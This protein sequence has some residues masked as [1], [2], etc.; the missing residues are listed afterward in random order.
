MRG[1]AEEL[2]PHFQTPSF[3]NTNFK[4]IDI[5]SSVRLEEDIIIIG[6]VVAS[7]FICWECVGKECRNCS[8]PMACEK[9]RK[10]G[11][12]II[13]L[14]VLIN[15]RIRLKYTLHCNIEEARTADT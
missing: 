15:T 12:A 5:I 13:R 2:A 11:I 8:G 14:L 7:C 4:D 10:I 3:L 1:L 9:V 6:V